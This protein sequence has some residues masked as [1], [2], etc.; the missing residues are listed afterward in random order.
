MLEEIFNSKKT[1]KLLGHEKNFDFFKNLLSIKKFP[2]VIMLAGEKG[3]GK[4]T[5]VNHLMYYYFDKENYDLFKKT[6]LIKSPFYQQFIDNIFSNIIYLNGTDFKNAKVE[7]IRKLKNKLLKTPILKDKRFIILDDV[8][9]FNNNSLNALLKVMEE[10]SNNYFLLINN[11]TAP[12]LDTIKSRCMIINFSLN[13]ESR[14]KI[15]SLL[16]DYYK[17]KLIFEKELIS[18]SPGQFL[19][20]NFFFNDKK[21][22]I[23]D[24]YISN[25]KKILNFYKKDKNVFYKFLIIFYTEYYL[26]KNNKV[27]LNDIKLIENRSSVIKNINDYF[28]YNLN[29]SSLIRS[30]ERSFK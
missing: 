21:M 15:K 6:L 23:E 2:N 14:I 28:L 17:Q 10:P 29:Q 7:E 1:L 3:I 12:I 30:L 9:S 26:T 27:I 19:K 25:I 18:V 5:F 8:E 13:T 20:F 16:I 24:N 22:N 11:K 4:S